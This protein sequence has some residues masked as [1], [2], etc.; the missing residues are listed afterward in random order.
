MHLS[1]SQEDIDYWV[2]TLLPPKDVYYLDGHYRPAPDPRYEIIP[3]TDLRD[4][5]Q[6]GAIEYL[7]AY[8]YWAMD[9][10][11]TREVLVSEPDYFAS[12][13][14]P[15]RARLFGLQVALKR[16][17][18]FDNDVLRGKAFQKMIQHAGVEGRL[19]LNHLIWERMNLNIRQQTAQRVA[20]SWEDDWEV[21][22][23][24]AS[25]APHIQQIANTWLHAEGAN[26]FGVALYAAANA[27]EWLHTWVDQATF[28]SGIE[29]SGYLL[30]ADT[31]EQAG[32]LLLFYDAKDHLR[33]AAFAVEQGLVLNKNGQ[34]KFQPVKLLRTQKL[35]DEWPD[36]KMAI[37]RR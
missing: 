27:G 4:H 23:L 22:D 33:H 37:W 14:M 26:C 31:Q 32:D 2:S 30:S 21:E 17:M 34:V 7:N 18:V 36:H 15:E 13:P 12:L 29:A 8:E 5:P 20:R 28:L 9:N 1:P 19:V 25:L 6:Y 16:G 10:D 24:P 35:L 3:V 11:K